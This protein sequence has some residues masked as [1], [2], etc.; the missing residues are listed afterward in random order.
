[1]KAFKKTIHEK[2]A[3]HSR[4]FTS[5]RKDCSGTPGKRVNVNAYE[6]PHVESATAPR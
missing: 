4:T 6:T 5:K 2:F 3:D 1:M